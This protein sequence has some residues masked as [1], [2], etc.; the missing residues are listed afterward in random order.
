[1]LRPDIQALQNFY[2]SPLGQLARAM[3]L[4]PMRRQWRDLRGLRLMGVGYAPP[5]MGPFRAETERSLAMMPGPQGVSPWMPQGRNLAFLGDETAWP[6]EEGALDRLLLIHGLESCRDE[7]ALLAEC[8]RVLTPTG[9]M[10]LVLPNRTG[11]WARSDASP[12]GHGRPYSLMQAE[13]LLARH[14]FSIAAWRGALYAPPWTRRG[15]MG[16]SRAWENVGRRLTPRLAGVWMIEA[17][18]VDQTPVFEKRE[19]VRARLRPALK[20]A[21]ARSRLDE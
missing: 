1:M 19:A 5:Y 3:L 21:A 11:W 15:L 16:W 7:D 14:G 18:R 9:R 8:A 12:W 17:A 13:R 20:P 4:P 2:R 6:F 10:I